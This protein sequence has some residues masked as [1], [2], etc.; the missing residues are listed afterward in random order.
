[1]SKQ[2]VLPLSTVDLA[3]GRLNFNMERYILPDRLKF[4]EL[5]IELSMNSVDFIE[6]PFFV[7]VSSS[8]CPN[9][10]TPTTAGA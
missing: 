3:N 4:V 10:I 2:L 8:A 5:P 1:M 7:N 6:L 9:P